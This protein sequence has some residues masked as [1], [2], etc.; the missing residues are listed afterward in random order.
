MGN[1]RIE[2]Q[3][4]V[5]KAGKRKED[6]V[7]GLLRSV[8]EIEK[9]FIIDRPSK[10]KKGFLKKEELEVPYNDRKE[11]I[12]AD[13]C[14]VRKAD[15]KLVCVIS[16]KKSFRERGGQTAYWAV[17]VKQHNKSYKYILVTPD[18]DQELY[19]PEKP[20]KKRK[21]RTILPFECDGVFIYSFKGKVYKEENFFVGEDYLLD[22]IRRLASE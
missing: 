4:E 14:V 21:W 22:F 18:T 12:D 3:R 15:K 16:V 2:R 9:N 5:T 19:N 17:K 7:I 10:I 20:K 11:K 13:I 8:P 1:E 6:E